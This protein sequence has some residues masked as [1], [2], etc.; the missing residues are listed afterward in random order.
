[1]IKKFLSLLLAVMMVV[2]VMAVGVVTS[3]AATTDG[4]K[5]EATKIYFDTDG[6]GWDMSQTKHK[7]AFYLAGGDFDT[8]ANPTKPI[9]WGGSKLIGTATEG[10]SGVFEFDPVAKLGY[11][12][13]PGV[14]YKL[15]FARIEGKNWK[16]QTYDLIFTTDCL[17]HV[18][19]CDGTEYENP[20]D[21]SKK[22][23]AAFWRDMDASE[24]GPV[25]QIS[26]IGNVVGTCLADGTTD[27]SLFTDFLT[28]VDGT[29]GKTKYENAYQ[30][31]VTS[32]RKT[33]QQMIDDIGIALGL[34]KQQVF[35]G[36]ARNEVETAWDYTAS[37]LAGDVVLPTEAPTE[38]PTD[39]PQPIV[40]G[41]CGDVDGSG[42]VDIV[43][44]T[45]IQ[46][47]LADIINA[48]PAMRIRGDVDKNG[49]LDIVDGTY[50]QRYLVG[51][52]DGFGIGVDMD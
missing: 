52:N 11:Q 1:M 26:S 33:E 38:A 15:I 23:Q 30:F 13:T 6:T 36:F 45:F 50:I 27:E 43:D 24:Y 32:G 4:F 2:S 49:E 14:Q 5:P 48:T 8:E 18:A 29:T 40:E 42:E 39:A 51:I 17:G 21:S 28:V 44:V 31:V 37:P 41:K 19:Y 46:R 20:V 9:S 25:K 10:Q 47:I 35:N 22:T 34:T 7:V 12:L 16:E 3:S